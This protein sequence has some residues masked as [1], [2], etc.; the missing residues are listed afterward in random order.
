MKNEKNVKLPLNIVESCCKGL[1]YALSGCINIHPCV[2][3]DIY[4]L[5]PLPCSHSTSSAI[6]PSRASDTAD[7]VRFLD[8]L[9]LFVAPFSA[10][11][12]IT[13]YRFTWQGLKSSTLVMIMLY[14]MMCK[15]IKQMQNTDAMYHSTTSMT[16]CILSQ[17]SQETSQFNTC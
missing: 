14:G 9:L 17:E 12:S 13:T 4:P 3:Q 11:R 1:K 15:D 7:H 2:L 5:G 8:D 6:T 16:A 10:F